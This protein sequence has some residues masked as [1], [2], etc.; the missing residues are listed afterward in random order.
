MQSFANSP[1]AAAGRDLD[2]AREIAGRVVGPMP[3]N[4]FIRRYFKLPGAPPAHLDSISFDSVP[5]RPQREGTNGEHRD[6]W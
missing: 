3:V 4:K 6:H 5:E 2:I 1:E